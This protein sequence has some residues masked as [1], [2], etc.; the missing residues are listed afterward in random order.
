MV[1]VENEWEAVPVGQAGLEMVELEYATWWF[2][3][4]EMVG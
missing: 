3:K 1:V 4:V 2:G